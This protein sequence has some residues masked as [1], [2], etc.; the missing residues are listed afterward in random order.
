MKRRS[1]F[2]W[3]G[4]VQPKAV[5]PLAPQAL[6]QV[7]VAEPVHSLLVAPMAAHQVKVGKVEDRG[8]SMQAFPRGL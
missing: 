1:S 8:L 7:A 6:I 3:A 2:L 5:N 4:Q